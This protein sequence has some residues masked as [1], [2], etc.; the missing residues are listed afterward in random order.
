MTIKLAKCPI[1]ATIYAGTRN[2][3]SVNGC[4]QCGGQLKEA[5]VE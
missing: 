2:L 5:T 4:P 3:V 1:C